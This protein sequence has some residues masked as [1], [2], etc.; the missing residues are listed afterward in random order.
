MGWD[1]LHRLT[2]A[3]RWSQPDGCFFGREKAVPC[4]LPFL[5]EACKAGARSVGTR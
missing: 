3:S 2:A 5:S 1:S 4:A